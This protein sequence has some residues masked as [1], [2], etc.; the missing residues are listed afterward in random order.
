MKNIILGSLFIIGLSSCELS[1]NEFTPSSGEADFSTFISIGDSYTAGYTDG[2]LG[3]TGQQSSFPALIAQQLQDVATVNYNQPLVQGDGSIGT[4]VIDANGTLNGYYQLAIDSETQ[5][6]APV[7]TVGNS[8]IF[9]EYV[10]NPDE[11][12]NNFGVP[13]AKST[14]LVTEGYAQANPFFARFAS[15]TNTSVLAD[16]LATDATFFTCWL[17]GNDVLTYAL[18]GGE[19]EVGLDV[20][21]IT[22]T[23]YFSSAM[24]AIIAG[25]TANGAKGVIANIPD[26]E[27]IPY[28]SYI[29]YNGLELDQETADALNAGYAQ[30]NAAAELYGLDQITFSEGYNSFVIE[31]TTNPLGMRQIKE[32]EKILLSASTNMQNENLWGTG[33]PIP[34]NYVLDADEVEAISTHVSEYNVKIKSIAEE[35][36]IAFVDANALMEELKDGITVDGNTYTTIFVSGGAFSLDGIHLTGKGYAII[37]NAFIKAINDKYNANI[38]LVNVNEQSGISIP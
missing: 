5:S 10:Y 25:L 28:F 12:I 32:G 2:A 30:Y 14:H 15:S 37:A 33:A 21:D 22:P 6:L 19:G 7:P 35:F 1:D 24:N 3:L 34:E 23:E 13:G 29:A 8:A 31:D 26:I 27:A 17:A 36:N 9:A 20:N 16:A 18:A 11:L 38:S 4:T